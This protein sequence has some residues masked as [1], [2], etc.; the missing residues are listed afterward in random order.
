MPKSKLALA[1]VVAALLVAAVVVPALADSQHGRPAVCSVDGGQVNEAGFGSRDG[2]DHFHHFGTQAGSL[3]EL[4]GWQ[5]LCRTNDNPIAENASGSARAVRVDL[6]V[7]VLLRAVLQR[8]V[9]DT[10]PA[11]A[12]NQSAWVAVVASAAVNTGSVGNPRTLVVTTPL[13]TEAGVGD[14]AL[15]LFVPGW[16]RTEV[17]AQVRH[18]NGTLSAAVQRTYGNW[19]G[20]GPVTPA[21]PPA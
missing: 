7:R 15:D 16:Y 5:N 20:D 17:R 3:T 8:W 10:D 18:S 13:I 14:P 21:T 19:L 6:A 9:L 12:G 2:F 11:T 1:A 4:E